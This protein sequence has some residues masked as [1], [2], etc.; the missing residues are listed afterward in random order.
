M[1]VPA[2]TND[3]TAKSGAQSRDFFENFVRTPSKTSLP[4]PENQTAPL[5]R[6]GVHLE[7]LFRLNGET[8]RHIRSSVK[9]LEYFVA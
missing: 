8:E 1:E 4:Q 5:G 9:H 2:I 7:G 6:V 3:G